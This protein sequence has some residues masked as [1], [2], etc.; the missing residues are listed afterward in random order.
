MC[1]KNR[2]SHYDKESH[3]HIRNILDIC[4]H[5]MHIHGNINDLKDTSICKEGPSIALSRTTQP[6][7][8]ILFLYHLVNANNMKLHRDSWAKK[9]RFM[10]ITILHYNPLLH[11]AT[12]FV[13]LI[14]KQSCPT[15]LFSSYTIS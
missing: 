12:F 15:K 2:A 9:D 4:T 8:Q 14:N 7:I 6:K 5:A 3:A 1:H 10:I 11:C 13:C